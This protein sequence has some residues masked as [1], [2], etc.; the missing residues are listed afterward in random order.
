MI[1]LAAWNVNATNPVD[2]GEMGQ[3][4]IERLFGLSDT[5]DRL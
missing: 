5:P 4:G 1:C 2:C 3:M